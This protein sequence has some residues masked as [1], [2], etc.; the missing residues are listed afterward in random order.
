MVSIIETVGHATAVAERLRAQRLQHTQWHDVNVLDNNVNTT[1][2]TITSSNTQHTI[3]TT[4]TASTFATT[5][6]QQ[7]IVNT[8]APA[9]TLST[10][11][12]T[13]LKGRDNDDD[14][15]NHA[16]NLQKQIAN[17][18]SQHHG[19]ADETTHGRSTLSWF[20]VLAYAY[21]TCCVQIARPQYSLLPSS[22]DDDLPT[23]LAFTTTTESA[24]TTPLLDSPFRN[25]RRI[26]EASSRAQPTTRL[27]PISV[28]AACQL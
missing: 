8:L 11:T 3:D 25:V 19:D 27:P 9:H 2:S 22:P 12:S 24:E 14:L 26:D 18:L 15:H 5:A 17:L 23:P 4:T 10:S 13:T 7:L 28:Q 20:Q 16:H 1:I 6:K 21:C